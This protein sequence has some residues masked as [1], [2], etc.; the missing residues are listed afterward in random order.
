[1]IVSA[2]ALALWIAMPLA[3]ATAAALLLAGMIQTVRL[4]RW[5]GDRTYREPLVLILHVA[6]AFVPIGF[7]LSAAG[8]FGLVA[9]SAGIHAWAVGAIGTMT[10]AIMTRAS[11]GHTGRPLTASV[12]TQA[13]YLAVV[14]A[15]LARIAASLLPSWSE[16]LL[17]VSAFAWAAA[18][19]GFG[20]SYM[21]ILCGARRT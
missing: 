18:F 21:P 13:I 3:P 17:H 15:A 12:L 11:L 2:A 6:Y 1:M 9:G 4:V 14:I 7:L 19:L 8:A 16:P 20:F 10:L 5:A